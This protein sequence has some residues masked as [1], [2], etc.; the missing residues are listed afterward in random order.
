MKKLFLLLVAV[1]SIGLYAS[2]QTRT[3]TGTVIDAETEEPALGASVV[4]AGEQLGVVADYDGNFSLVVAA[5]VTHIT[6]TYIGFDPVTVPIGDGKNLVI[7]LQKANNALDEVIAVAYGTAK[8]AEYTG[9]AGVVK[10]EQLENALVSNITQA[11][12]GNVA[13]VQTFSSDGAPGSAPSIQIR[14]TGSINA[15]SSPLYVVDGV[16]YQGSIGNISPADIESMVVLKDAASTALYGARGANGVVLITTRS[17][18]QGKA[19]IDVNARWGVNTRAVPM[20]DVID[21]PRMFMEQTYVA[22]ANSRTRIYGEDDALANAYVNQNIWNR[23]GYQTWT[24]PAGQQA[25]NLAG[26]FNPNATMGYTDGRYYWQPDDWEDEALINGLRQEYS[27]S[28]TGGTDRMQYYVSGTYLT[29]EGIIKGSHFNRLTARTRV[30]YQAL[31]WLKIGTD[32]SYIYSN[33]AYPGENTNDSGTSSGNAFYFINKLAPVYPMYVRNPD[34]SIMYNE[35]Y[36]NPIYD[37]G[38]GIDYGN[39]MIGTTRMPQGNPIGQLMYDVNDYLD[40]I[41][42]AKWYAILTPVK[43]LTL[44]QKVNYFVDNARTHSL[45]NGLYGQ[46]RANGG[47]VMQVANRSMVTSLQSLA[48]YTITF[49]EIHTIAALLGYE[50]EDIRTEYVEGIGDNLYQPTVP[51]V[52]NTI[53]NKKGYGAYGELSHRGVFFQGKYTLM[54]RYYLMGS[55]RRD[56]S[57]R[58]APGHRWGTFWSLSAGWDLAK[59]DFMM[60]ARENWLD[61]FKFRASFGQTGNDRIGN[62]TFNQPW[63][64]FYQVTGADGVF[65]DGTL[66]QKGNPELTWEKSNSF[67]IGFDFSILK[68]KLTGT[69]EFFNR[70]TDDM[71][72]SLPVA[73]SLGYSSIP[74]NVGSLRNNG[75]EVELT[76]TPIRNRNV[77]WEIFANLT[78][79]KNKVLKLAPEILNEKGEWVSSTYQRMREGHSIY[80]IYLPVY[81]GV[82]TDPE[83]RTAG[84]AMYLA[85]DEDGMEYKTPDWTVARTTNSK[86]TED[87]SPDVYGGF[88]TRVSFFGVDFSIQCAYQLGGQLLDY[89]YMDLMGD[90]SSVGAWHKDV[91]GAWNPAANVNSDIPMLITEGEFQYANATSTRFLT[92]SDY[93]SINNITLGYTLPNRWLNKLGIQSCR[94]Y[95]AAENVA[96]FSARKGLDPRQGFLSSDNSTYSP[97]RAISGGIQISF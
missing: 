57:S 67:N 7:R 81:A 13:G 8:R 65:S 44:T 87:L 83:S 48:N 68:G 91:I 77:N 69:A 27:L 12:S 49:N 85:L 79:G 18:K 24:I 32:I 66:V 95:G 42:D 58:F 82:D 92:S 89:G 11:L 21:D 55:I 53:D 40:D 59:E 5:N 46:F 88:G 74:S 76:Y 35:L 4:P 39:G 1:L 10:S 33:T 30:D 34:G 26:K 93:L 90:G 25:F 16:P 31:D 96:L 15:S 52:N 70:Q 2:A 14:G 84:Y 86:Y 51:F 43:G 20:Y 64:D 41:I 19:R 62:S 63:A 45:A 54:D 23:Y 36:G 17:G 6:V 50:S 80:E 28:I 47:Q 73:P 71:L 9:S 61:V 94:V 60:T 38:D 56:G 97:I 72:F 75:F 29:D 37:Y 22:M 78:Y 3:V